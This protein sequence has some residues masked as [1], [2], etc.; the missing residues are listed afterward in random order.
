M[1]IRWQNHKSCHFFNRL[2]LEDTHRCINR[3]IAPPPPFSPFS[4]LFSSLIF[5]L[6]LVRE[7]IKIE[8]KKLTDSCCFINFTF[9]A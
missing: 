3:K 2:I 8:R 7:K 6:E 5:F 1:R 9:L 4:S